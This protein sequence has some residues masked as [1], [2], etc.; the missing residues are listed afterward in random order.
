MLPSKSVV[1]GALL[2]PLFVDKYTDFSTMNMS[3]NLLLQLV[4]FLSIFFVI[5]TYL[6]FETIFIF[7][8]NIVFL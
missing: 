8:A 2:K 4:C 6:C 1:G 3:A 7:D 5:G